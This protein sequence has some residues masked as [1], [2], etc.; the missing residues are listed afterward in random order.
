MAGRVVQGQSPRGIIGLLD[1]EDEDTMILRYVG[2]Y[3][4]NNSVTP[5]KIWILQRNTVELSCKVVKG[6]NILCRYKRA[7]LQ[8]RS[9]MSW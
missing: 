9:V 4:P 8:P 6:P 1:L 5:H 2:K 3:S 7:T